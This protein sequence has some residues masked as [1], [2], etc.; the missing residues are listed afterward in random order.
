[1]REASGRISLGLRHQM[2]PK[3]VQRNVLHILIY[4]FLLLAFV[5]FT[6]GVYKG[7]VHL[8]QLQ[9]EQITLRELPSAL[10]LSLMRMIASYTAA[11]FFSFV[12]GLLAARSIVGERI[13]LPLLNIGQSVP[14]IAF[15]PAAITFFIGITN[16]H[17]IGIEMA[18][19]FLIF[20]SQAWNMAFAVYEATKK[21]PQDNFD[22]ISSFGIRGSQ[23]FW[24][25]YAPACVPRLVYNSIL[26]WSNGWYF[27]VACEIIAVGPVQYNLP[28]I[29]SFLARAAEQDQ[30]PLVLWGLLALTTLIL[31][32]DALI[33]RP[34]S[35]WA[36]KFRQDY[37]TGTPSLR[38]RSFF[39]AGG[40]H[41]HVRFGPVLRAVTSAAKRLTWVLTFP[42]AWL[43][44][45]V[46]LPLI[47]DLPVTVARASYEKLD[48]SYGS[49]ALL[50]WNRLV[51]RMRWIQLV[52]LWVLGAVIGVTAG[53][54][55]VHWLR[56]PWP[57]IAQELPMALLISTGR[58][59]LSLAIS[60][61]L[62]IPVVLWSW[63]RP[64]LRQT[65]TTIAQVG[66]SLPAVA[67]FPLIILVVARRLGGGM[68][69]AAIL[70]LLTGMYW[71]LLFNAL[72][73]AAIIPGDLSEAIRSIGLS[74]PQTWKRLVLPSI[75]PAL[76]T[77]A[78]TAWGGGWNALVFS[79]YV[80]FKGQD[81]QVRGIGALLN[82]SVYKLGDT[83]AITLCVAVMV[84]W[85]I[86]INI[87][88]WRPLYQSA[89]ERS[90]FDS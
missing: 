59:V 77:G 82:Y 74:R 8:A 1:M 43:L 2:I 76:I 75:Q 13:I 5:A 35:I 78:I 51:E 6:V 89:S 84:A 80:S 62:T 54:S 55:L 18:A 52:A 73:G 40:G 17:R 41:S 53:F 39:S 60:F 24:K 23:R 42:I 38:T 29:G 25:L 69:L 67:L 30:I 56:P 11:L 10:I 27:L 19:C 21:I 46:L 28:G 65:L 20:T 45:E 3:Y 31:G 15:F 34:A 88:I 32:M 33:W 48:R 61:I 36:E 4:L 37:S 83:R 68:E 85:I 58:L 49:L 16:G 81:L 57:P 22:A 9:P 7:G 47:W 14:V 44:T 12:L 79:E 26:S 70:L 72:G 66:A 86:F 63:N 50:R 90:K 64:R 71:Y 87:V